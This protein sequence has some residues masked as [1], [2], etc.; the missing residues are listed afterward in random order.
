MKKILWANCVYVPISTFFMR[1]TV[2]GN[3]FVRNRSADSFIV[4]LM[5][6]LLFSFE[7]I[8]QND[9]KLS[10]LVHS[11][12]NSNF[13][14][15]HQEEETEGRIGYGLELN[16]QFGDGGKRLRS[17]LGIAFSRI[18]KSRQFL[19]EDAT[20]ELEELYGKFPIHYSMWDDV[21]YLS[22]PYTLTYHFTKGWQLGSRLSLDYPLGTGYYRQ[23]S[24][25]DGQVVETHKQGFDSTKP[26]LWNSSIGLG[27]QL[28]KTITINE[29]F[30]LLIGTNFKVFALLAAR[31]NDYFPHEESERPYSLGISVGLVF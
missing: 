7:A 25:D 4:V 12:Y 26:Y 5:V 6:V 17:S 27:L 29:K 11:N 13:I 10:F 21:Y 14:T 2:I 20:P 23:R 3:M 24:S 18:G 31:K 1:N 30:G 9:H 22:F 16:Y 8:A 15:E 19:W 28:A